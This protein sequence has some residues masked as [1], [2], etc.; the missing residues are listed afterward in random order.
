[1][2]IFSDWKLDVYINWQQ[3]LITDDEQSSYHYETKRHEQANKCEHESN[4]TATHGH[5]TVYE[6][7]DNETE[8]RECERSPT[9]DKVA[10]PK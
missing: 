10:K 6:Y 2:Y 3:E 5:A 8:T 7:R 1:M 9:L 4:E